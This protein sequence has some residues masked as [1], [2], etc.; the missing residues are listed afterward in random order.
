MDCFY[1]ALLEA[2]EVPAN[3]ELYKNE[4]LPA[5]K[6]ID[7]YAGQDQEPESFSNAFLPALYFSWT[8]NYGEDYHTAS[9]Q[10]RLAFENLRDTSNLSLQREKALG[11][12][13]MA[14]ITDHILKNITTE[15]T[16]TL[17]LTDEGLVLE[18]TLTDVFLLNYECVYQGNEK[19]RQRETVAGKFDGTH[20][21]KSLIKALKENPFKGHI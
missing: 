4:K 1:L 5:P 13:K 15:V 3:K 20:I 6:V 11:F 14:K 7:F 10:F 18:P 16:G 8:V 2:F 17:S 19:T 9:L 21:N 12:F